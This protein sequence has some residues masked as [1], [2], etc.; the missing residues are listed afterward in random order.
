VRGPGAA[1]L[2]PVDRLDDA[3]LLAW[4]REDAPHGDLTT[5]TLGLRD[6]PATLRCAARSAMRVAAVE[7]AARL[8]ELCGGRARPLARSGD[9]VVAGA[10]LLAA[11]GGAAALLLA[12]KVAQTAVEV[13]S[14][15]AT[16]AAAIVAAARSGGRAVPVACTRK[17]WPGGRALAARAVTA[18]GA[19]MHRLGLSETVL[20]FPEHRALLAP[21]DVAVA[22][23]RLATA[24]P[25]KKIVVE[26]GDEAEAL[27][28]AAAGVDVLQLER[29]TPDQVRSLRAAL[30]RAG[31]DR[32]LLA[33]AGGVT[34]ANA[35]AHAAAG[36]DLLV[37]SAPYAAPPADVRVRIARA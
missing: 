32:P 27:A 1:R 20:V 17:A 16:E 11:E 7:E 13:A 37:T 33:P 10:P 36:A 3:T 22:V 25:E 35:A 19:V 12:W 8:V 30:D 28:L 15:I 6:E 26:T 24:L 9:D 18:G 23:A 14:G 29:F 4:L 5:A 21:G 31:L 2:A 34:R